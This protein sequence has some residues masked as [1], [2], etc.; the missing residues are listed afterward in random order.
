MDEELY[1]LIVAAKKGKVEAFA[2]LMGRFKGKVYRQAYAMLNDESEAQDVAQE[3]FVKAYYSLGKLKSEYAFVS[4]LTQIVFHLC[5][6]RLQKKKKEEHLTE[7]LQKEGSFTSSMEQAHLKLT[8][9][10]ALAQLSVEHRE[11][12]VLRDI[13]GF[14]YDEIAEVLNIPVGTVKSRVHLSRLALRNE[15]MK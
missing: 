2:Q 11:V 15:L 8:I 13:Q 3:S 9:E 6:D 4:W 7:N 14:S 12:I 1:Q 5:Y 10:E